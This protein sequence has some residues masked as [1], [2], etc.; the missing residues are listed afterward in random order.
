MTQIPTYH[1][2][3]AIPVGQL[4]GPEAPSYS[5][6]LYQRNYTWGEEQIHRLIYDILDEAEQN[7]S[8]DYFLGNLVVSTPVRDDEPLD[9]IDGQQRLTTLYILLIKLA[10]KSDARDRI[11]KL[12]PLTYEARDKATRALRGVGDGSFER[13]EDETDQEDSGIVRASQIIDQFLDSG[14]DGRRFQKSEV[15]NY[16]LNRVLLIRMPIDRSADL[17]KYFEI[18]NTRG[19]QLSPVDIVKARLLRYLHDPLDRA[20]FNRIWIACSD[21]EHYVGMSITAGSTTQRAKVLGRDW[22]AMPTADF[23]LLRQQLIEAEPEAVLERSDKSESSTSSTALSLNDA[24][25]FYSQVGRK[26]EQDDTEDGERFT[27]QITFPTVLLHILAVRG[28]RMGS[29]KESDRQLDDKMLVRRFTEQLASV[30]CAQQ[31]DW[32]RNFA[33]DLLRIR[34]LFDQF[35]LKRDAT[36]TTGHEST[37]D[38]EPGSWS[39]RRLVRNESRSRGRSQDTPQYRSTF[40]DDES[41]TGAGSLQ[42]RILLLQSALRITY[43]SPRTMHWITHVLRY[44]TEL[45]DCDES[46]TARGLLECLETYAVERVREAMT[47]DPGSA[48]CGPDGMLLG[49]EIPRIVFTY[50]DYLL[51]EETGQWDFIFSYRTSIE[52]F[53]PRTPD[54][55]HSSAEYRVDDQRLLDW[56]GNLALVTVS[57][58]SKFSNYHPA[59]KA[60]NRE[61]RRQSLKLELMAKQAHAGSWN[62]EDVKNHH[63]KMMALLRQALA[64]NNIKHVSL[65]V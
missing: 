44:V 64:E 47:P 20:L 51:V 55:V 32:V 23:S 65:E 27:S 24:V 43:T 45:A 61:A 59:E 17:N 22:D 63:D 39:L 60:N 62:D 52:H 48:A 16:L 28:D 50:L 53:S 35:I 3:Q 46:I 58:N 14:S 8:H 54:I 13:V 40:G 57:A 26:H 11:G 37:T 56:F 33:T 25:S 38:E 6:P 34:H 42:R 5:I 49:F 4:F 41:G 19:T 7:F 31:S 1:E 2:V 12:Q 30:P 18:M 10:E 29:V 36:M 9:V 15:I 21:M